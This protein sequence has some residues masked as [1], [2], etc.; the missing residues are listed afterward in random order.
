[1]QPSQEAKLRKF[2]TLLITWALL[3]GFFFAYDTY[4]V[5]G[6]REYLVDRE[7]RALAGLSRR[8]ADE[9]D[10]SRLSVESALKLMNSAVRD[11]TKQ[12]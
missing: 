9:F 6:Q 8:I 10:R 4:V 2:I 7:F 1:M 5:A 12:G 3:L 11:S